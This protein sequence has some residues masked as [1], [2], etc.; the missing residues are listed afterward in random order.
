MS[1]SDSII[2]E[3]GAATKDNNSEIESSILEDSII[4]NEYEA[5]NYKVKHAQK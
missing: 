5:D 4:R 3:V 2:D 1:K